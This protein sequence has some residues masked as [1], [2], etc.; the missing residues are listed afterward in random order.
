MIYGLIMLQ[1]ETT[2]G[3]RRDIWKDHLTLDIVR[4]EITPENDLKTHVSDI[5]CG[6]IPKVDSEDGVPRLI[7][8][9]FDDRELIEDYERGN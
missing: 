3:W 8:N 2:K 5:D 4:M 7:H 1:D 9:S 6:C